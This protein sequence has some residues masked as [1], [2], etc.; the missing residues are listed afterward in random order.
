MHSE[1][2][3]NEVYISY[4]EIV[5]GHAV[6]II[7]DISEHPEFRSYLIDFTNDN[8]QCIPYFIM[9]NNSINA[10]NIISILYVSY[11]ANMWLDERTALESKEPVAFVYDLERKIKGYSEITYLMC[12]GSP[13]QR[14]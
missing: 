4:G 13:I 7:F 8:P 9:Y 12:N 2:E 1:I 11:D 6:G 5:A 10:G 3:F 14:R